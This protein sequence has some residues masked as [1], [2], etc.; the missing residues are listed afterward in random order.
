MRLIQNGPVRATRLHGLSGM[1]A[2]IMLEFQQA[3]K[4]KSRALDVPGVRPCVARVRHVSGPHFCA[5]H[6]RAGQPR[7]APLLDWSSPHPLK[8]YAVTSCTKVIFFCLQYCEEIMTVRIPVS[9][10][11][12]QAT[13]WAMDGADFRAHDAAIEMGGVI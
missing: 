13:H 3:L 8:E 11:V 4:I 2:L 6:C 12:G 7:A 9:H 10:A 5:D 1:N